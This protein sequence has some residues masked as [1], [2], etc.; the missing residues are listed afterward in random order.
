MGGDGQM[1]PRELPRLLDPVVNNE[2]GYSKG[3]RLVHLE[4]LKMPRFRRFGNSILTLLTKIASGYWSIVDPQNGYTA[5]SR[6]TI[7]KINFGKIFD[8]YGYPNDMLVELN[9]KN[10]KVNDVEMAPCYGEEKSGIKIGRYTIRLSWLLLRG[11]FRRI[12]TKYG[13]LRFHPLWLFYMGGL[14][15]LVC[16]LALSLNL[17]IY[18]YSGIGGFSAG[19]VLLPALFLITGYLSLLFALLFDIQENKNLCID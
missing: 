17:L 9:I 13:G 11:F 3:N 10:I 2:A 15:F 6:E 12:N 4:R 1:S 5:I 14:T 8:G 16:G 7:E 19:T 18:F